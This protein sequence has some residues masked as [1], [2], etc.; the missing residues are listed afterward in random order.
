MK[1]QQFDP[2]LKT[3]QP[4]FLLAQPNFFFLVVICLAVSERAGLTLELF[5]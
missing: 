2:N 3:P 5:L 1:A 4:D